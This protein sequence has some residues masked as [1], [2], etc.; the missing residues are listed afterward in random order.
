MQAAV[1]T[2]DHP[3]LFRRHA[4]RPRLTRLLDESRAQAIVITAPAGYG[5]TTLATEWLQGREDVFWYHATNASADVAAF[6]AGLADLVSALLPGAGDRLKQRLRVADTPERAARPLAELL[7]EDLAEWP[8]S[9]LLVVDDYH[10]VADSAPVED[11]FDWLLTLAPQLRVL[12]TSRR[13][14]RWASARRILYAEITEIGRDQL[15]MNAEEAGRALGDDRSSESV[16]A[17]VTQAEGWPALIGLAALTASR[18]IP[19]ERVSEALYRYFA[20]EVVRREAPEVERFM[21]LASVP[22]TVDARIAREVLGIED[23]EPTLAGLVEEGLLH[24]AGEQ[25]RFHPLLRSFLRQKLETSTPETY[26]ELTGRAISDSRETE[27][28]ED[29]FELAFRAQQPDLAVAILVDATASML[30]SGRIET[31]ERWFQECGAAAIRTPGAILARVEILIRKGQLSDAAAI[32][33]ELASRLASGDQHS[34]RAYFLA[35]QALYL[36]SGSQQAVQFHRRAKELATNARDLKHALWGLFMTENELGLADAEQHLAELDAMASKDNDLDTRLRVAVGRQAAGSGHGSFAGLWETSSPLIPLAS[37]ATDPMARTTLFANRSYLCVAHADYERGAELASTALNECRQLGFD[38]AKG[39]CLATLALAHAGLRAFKSAHQALRELAAVA[40]EQDNHYLRCTAEI[41]SMR[42]ALAR[43]KPHEAIEGH[44][45]NFAEHIPVPAAQGEYLGVL[46]LAAAAAGDLSLATSS[47][48]AARQ[49]TTAIEARFF[50]RFADLILHAS[51]SDKARAEASRLAADIEDAVFEDALVLA[52][53]AHPPILELLPQEGPSASNI[54]SVMR[55]AN[56][57]AA[58]TVR[59]RTAASAG[60]DPVAPLTPRE[61]EV[62]ALLAA[63]LSNAEIAERLFISLS[64]AKVHV[65]HILKK[66]G[67]KTRLQAA[68]QAQSQL[69]SW[70]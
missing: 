69:G 30:A 5:K 66:L 19:G 46:A 34:S 56:D 37:H 62:L 1:E 59:L 44:G 35:G 33:K 61:Q 57:Q 58:A 38:F 52:Y 53:R 63:G 70:D 31:L 7:A 27:C 32:A 18:E 36:G 49:V 42:V 40:N 6:S 45:P 24:P 15:A 47:A 29:A 68:V 9:A 43:G 14:P 3:P 28:W 2:V 21:L 12:V 26:F 13:R 48:Q 51:D 39:Y 50:S 25:L 22:A 60:L 55:R 10:L 16:R 17:L 65:Q 20:E 4:R 11:F 8:E 54:A 23:P 67:A 64:T 41:T